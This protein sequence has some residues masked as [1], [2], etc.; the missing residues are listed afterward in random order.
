MIDGCS[1]PLCSTPTCF[2][3]RQRATQRPLRKLTALSARTIACYLATQA[4]PEEALCPHKPRDT[5][6]LRNVSLR[7]STSRGA[8]S[9]PEHPGRGCG[10]DD[11][12]PAQDNRVDATE[13]TRPIRASTIEPELAQD[14]AETSQAIAR[15][16]Y[17]DAAQP[18]SA[19][20]NSA[21]E[22]PTLRLAPVKKD[23]RSFAQNLFDTGPL[24]RMFSVPRRASTKCE[25]EGRNL[26]G[27]LADT[28]PPS[29]SRNGTARPEDEPH[30]R[31]QSGVDTVPKTSRRQETP[32]N[33]DGGLVEEQ[34][35]RRRAQ[36]IAF[37]KECPECLLPTS[38]AP[39]R[40]S[41]KDAQS[42]KPSSQ[43]L[44]SRQA[45]LKDDQSETQPA[46]RSLQ[47]PTADAHM[48]TR[49]GRKL[50][51]Q[52]LQL[53]ESTFTPP[54]PP[55]TPA[56]ERRAET[57]APPDRERGKQV[58][59]HISTRT[60]SKVDVGSAGHRPRSR[61][62]AS[63]L[64][65]LSLETVHSLN[66]LIV[67][68][69]N[70]SQDHRRLYRY[71]DRGVDLRLPQERARAHSRREAAHSYVDQSIYYVFSDP[72][73]MLASFKSDRGN[74]ERAR[75]VLSQ[76]LPRP[77][78]L[79]NAFRLLLR[80]K[81]TLV[82][83]S[84]WEGIESLFVPPP[85]LVYPKSPRRKPHLGASPVG[86]R[87]SATAHMSS[88]PRRYLE[89][90][91]AA[92]IIALSLHALVAAVPHATAAFGFALAGL[93]ASGCVGPDMNDSTRDADRSEL[94]GAVMLCVEVFENE[95]CL[96][97]AGRLIR[98]L[99]TRIHFNEI[100]TTTKGGGPGI[101]DILCTYLAECRPPDALV[102]KW[103]LGDG[104]GKNLEGTGQGPND[105][106]WAMPVVLVEWIRTVI[107]KSWDGKGE[108]G[109]FGV[110]GSALTILHHLCESSS[111][112]SR[113][114]LSRTHLMLICTSQT[115]SERLLG[116]R[117]WPSTFL[118]CR[119][120]WTPW[121]PRSSGSRR[122]RR[123]RTSICSRTRSS[124]HP[125]PCSPT[126]APSI[127]RAC[128]A[129]LRCR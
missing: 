119:T 23:P 98:A 125:R 124:S 127:F 50:A 106:P 12:V 27:T 126:S 114:D 62:T 21:S 71:F 48:A 24:S 3:F 17:G 68:A 35:Q 116:W 47:V 104:R 74:D 39:R 89:D 94:F 56:T 112:A 92:H 26:T 18:S 34:S 32:G 28:K 9:S 46:Y 96:R 25:S 77:P 120:D 95:Q 22:A 97:L 108:V 72:E 6:L 80:D 93:R 73:A 88:R 5:A 15:D 14:R 36:R 66:Q 115:T 107:M 110:V 54:S 91:E 78:D 129:R 128:L 4:D 118:T 45:H 38:A 19:F 100:L 82:L 75:G 8:F 63:S 31:S 37:R 109:R 44:T 40:T 117:R 111:P 7:L 61:P 49:H 53:A 122:R 87:P 65:H 105:I 123:A 55:T 90:S 69:D 85:E 101:V 76:S 33:T 86:S 51:A 81:L 52:H 83:D 60:G 113:A 41:P 16:E 42:L 102:G 103:G 64:S 59:D 57:G 1:E 43:V 2:T 99:A 29:G 20:S 67:L 30:E 13:E 121:K 10:L 58:Q 84:L 79:D 70:V 11:A